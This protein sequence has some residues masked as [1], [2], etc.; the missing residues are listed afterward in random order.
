MIQTSILEWSFGSNLLDNPSNVIHL[1]IYNNYNQSNH[2]MIDYQLKN[3]Q[4]IIYYTTP[5][6]NSA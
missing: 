3:F 2:I 6:E 4:L 5:I 1:V